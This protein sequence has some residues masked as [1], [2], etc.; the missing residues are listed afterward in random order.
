MCTYKLKAI[1]HWWS[2][3][4]IPRSHKAQ[5]SGTWVPSRCCGGLWARHPTPCQWFPGP[6]QGLSRPETGGNEKCKAEIAVPGRGQ[7]CFFWSTA[8]PPSTLQGL[9]FKPRSQRQFFRIRPAVTIVAPIKWT[10]W[11]VRCRISCC[12]YSPLRSKNVKVSA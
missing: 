11:L 1:I 8:S 12:H 5:H 9:I 4:P 6:L 7:L 10:K 2:C 3:H